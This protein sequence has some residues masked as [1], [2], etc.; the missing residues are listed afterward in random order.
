MLTSELVIVFVLIEI[1][2]ESPSRIVLCVEL[3][4]ARLAA[5][6]GLG[7]VYLLSFWVKHLVTLKLFLPF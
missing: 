3:G 7:Q 6:S 1:V 4:G 5:N 2:V